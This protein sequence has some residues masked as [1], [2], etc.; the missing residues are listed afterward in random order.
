MKS[1]DRAPDEAREIYEHRHDEGEWSEEAVP[2]SVR[3]TRTSVVS[4]RL[5]SEEF[6]VLEAAARAAGESLSEYVR[7]AIE[8]RRVGNSVPTGLQV[9]SVGATTMQVTSPILA[10]W[11]E[12]RASVPQDVPTRLRV[13]LTNKEE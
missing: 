12:T 8:V 7:R 5:P 9:S 6:D 4:F 11:T 2:V 1:Q 13:L 3:P 10:A